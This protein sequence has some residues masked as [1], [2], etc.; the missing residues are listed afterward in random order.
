M[1]SLAQRAHVS[2]RNELGDFVRATAQNECS[3]RQ[4]ETGSPRKHQLASPAKAPTAERPRLAERDSAASILADIGSEGVRHE[5]RHDDV[6][7]K[8]STRTDR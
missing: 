7:G 1:I 6:L 2:N 8:A 5:L 4:R 3:A